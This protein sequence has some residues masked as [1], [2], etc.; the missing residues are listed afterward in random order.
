MQR[1]GCLYP[2]RFL[3][4][5]ISRR[6]HL[7]GH[8]RSY[9]FAMPDLRNHNFPISI[10]IVCQQTYW[11][12][13]YKNTIGIHQCKSHRSCMDCLST[14]LNLKNKNNQIVF[15]LL[16][17]FRQECEEWRI[18]LRGVAPGKHSS[19]KTSKRWRSPI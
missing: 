1:W 5:R 12:H 17:I 15:I 19:E 6:A 14:N 18:H 7:Q 4:P 10:R 11:Y 13:K 2:T 3:M 8:F 16:A 9:T